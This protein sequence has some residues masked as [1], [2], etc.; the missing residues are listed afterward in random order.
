MGEGCLKKRQKKVT[1]I[2]LPQTELCILDAY[3]L[4]IL[5]RMELSP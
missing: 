4:G 3:I 5:L 2:F 1:Q